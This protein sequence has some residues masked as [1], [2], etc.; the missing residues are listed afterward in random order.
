MFA[1]PSDLI[2]WF[3]ETQE[4]QAAAHIA[5]R[6]AHLFSVPLAP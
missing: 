5:R 4:A 6:L 2:V 3:K 1:R